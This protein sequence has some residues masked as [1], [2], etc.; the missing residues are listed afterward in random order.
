MTKTSYKITGNTRILK[1]TTIRVVGFNVRV[2]LCFKE[3][4]RNEKGTYSGRG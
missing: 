3:L 4:F 1:H 2:F